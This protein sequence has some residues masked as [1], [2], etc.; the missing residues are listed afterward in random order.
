MINIA[1]KTTNIKKCPNVAI[2]VFAITL[3]PTPLN[4]NPIIV[5]KT[6]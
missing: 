1:H 5:P 4:V 6:T 2:N 3:N